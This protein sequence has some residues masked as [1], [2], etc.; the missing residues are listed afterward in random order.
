MKITNLTTAFDA[1]SKLQSEPAPTA[2][3]VGRKEQQPAGD[4]VNLSASA[5]LAQAAMGAVNDTADIRYDK[6]AKA[7]ALLA[8]GEIGNDPARLADAIVARLLENE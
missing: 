1:I 8:S 2:G 5:Q 4:R 3:A 6:V 7:K